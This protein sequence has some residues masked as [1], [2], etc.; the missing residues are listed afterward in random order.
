MEK[1]HLIHIL[2]VLDKKEVKELRKWVNSP[3]HNLRRD[4]IDLFEYLV[5]GQHLY[6]EK[7]LEKERVFQA[8]YPNKTFND[9]EM[10]QVMHFLLKAVENFLVYNELLKDEVRTQT[11]LAK[12]YRKRQLAKQFQKAI[13]T[14]REIQES[15][16]YRNHQYF[17]NEYFLQF[18][19]FN[20]LSSLGRTVPLNLQEVSDSNDISF[21]INKLQVGCIM[22]S[23]QKVFKTNYDNGLLNQALEYVEQ[24]EMLLEYPPIAIYYF[25]YK[26]S[27]NSDVE[28]YFEKLKGR[29]ATHGDLFPIHEIRS[30][31]LFA[32]NYC[33]GKMNRGESKFIREAFTLYQ[34]GLQKQIF[35]DNGLLSR[36]TF[37]NIVPIGLQLKEYQW[38]KDFI[39]TYQHNLEEKYKDSLVQFNLA[40]LYFETKDYKQA[41]KLIARFDYDDM[42][43]MLVAK[44]M[45]LKMYYELDEFNAL[46]SLLGSMKT[47]LQRK[48]VMGYH[49]DNYK[50][51]IQYTKKL[52]KLTHYDK[53]KIQK[54]KQEIE[55]TN[56]LTERK[57]LLAQ[58]DK[59]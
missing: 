14:G 26:A 3:A 51:I 23:H 52:L 32:I 43:I 6:A 1:S 58:L 50:N 47:Y 46:D 42:L 37:G 11:M 5:V 24:N 31:Y 18:E 7:H 36:F 33:I 2:R 59:M 45:L 40:H 49:K 15:Q 27:V 10:R 21:I 22:L 17:E 34:Q 41:M 38:V 53:E 30:I 25:V 4:V 29:I 57:W 48:K 13:E 39:E 20:Y 12:V 16:P 28:D 8:I 35:L 9:A 55:T 44:T 54:L 19:Q 56:P